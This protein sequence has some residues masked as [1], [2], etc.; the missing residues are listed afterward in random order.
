[1]NDFYKNPFSSYV[2]NSFINLSDKCIEKLLR[3]SHTTKTYLA[4]PSNE[5]KDF[6][7][8]SFIKKHSSIFGI[9]FI[10]VQQFIHLI[11]K[12]CYKKD[13]CFPSHYELMFFLEERISA[14]LTSDDECILALKEYVADKPERIIALSSNLSHIF[15]DYMLYGKGALPAWL[16]KDSWQTRLYQDVSKKW[17]SIISAMD[18]CPP[19]PFPISLHIFGVDEIPALYLSFIEKLSS[20]LSFSF[21]FLSPSPVFWG[22]LISRKKAPI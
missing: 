1:M 3:E 9:R 18:L 6:F 8:Q 13:L 22:D 16:N 17:V 15:L 10:T 12:I 14:L 7:T 21:Y 19:P 2:S 5:V 11:L 20:H 4:Y